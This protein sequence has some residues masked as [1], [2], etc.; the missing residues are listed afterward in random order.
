[1]IYL[2]FLRIFTLISK[3]HKPNI[4]CT[5][6]DV[7]G[8][9]LRQPHCTKPSICFLIWLIV[10]RYDDGVQRNVRS[11][12]ADWQSE[13]IFTLSICFFLTSPSMNVRAISIATKSPKSMN[14]SCDTDFFNSTHSSRPGRN[15]QALAPHGP[16]FCQNEPAVK[17]NT[18]LTSFRSIW[19]SIRRLLS[20]S[21]A[22]VLFFEDPRLL[23]SKKISNDQELIQSDTISWPQNQK[24]NN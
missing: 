3:D 10:P 19:S 1:M 16:G 5:I 7:R 22:V 12:T 17:M 23:Q 24:G 11:P 15:T 9:V 20:S 14:A 8:D 13:K 4:N 6:T 2:W 21:W 18:V